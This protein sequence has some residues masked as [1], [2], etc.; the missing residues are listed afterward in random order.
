MKKVN[1]TDLNKEIARLRANFHDIN[2]GLSIREEKTLAYLEELASLLQK[3]YPVPEGWKMVPIEPTEAMVINGFES[4]PDEFFSKPQDWNEY[5]EMSGCG[6]AAH[7]AKLCYSAM[8][9]SAPE[10]P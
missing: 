8:L 3:S 4:E 6:K 10:A 9:A 1:L 2:H 7:R 5:E